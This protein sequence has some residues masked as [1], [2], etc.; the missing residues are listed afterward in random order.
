MKFKHAVG[1]LSISIGLIWS[2]PLAA[3]VGQNPNTDTQDTSTT[4]EIP[5]L[6]GRL[7]MT[8]N[9]AGSVD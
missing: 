6:S 1:I 9:P 7:S 5:H 2:V 4:D 8:I 3:T